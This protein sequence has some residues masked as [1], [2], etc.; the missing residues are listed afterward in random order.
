MTSQPKDLLLLVADADIEQ[1]MRGLLEN[2]RRLG[3][4]PVSYEIKRHLERDA[5]CARH[6]I[7]FLRLFCKQFRRALVIFDH[8]GSDR[9]SETREALESSLEQELARN[10]WKA[11]SVRV[12]ALEPEIE[13]WVWSPS[14]HVAKVLGWDDWDHLRSWLVDRQ[15]LDQRSNKPERPKEAMLAACSTRTTPSILRVAVWKA[16]SKCEPS[17]V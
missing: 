4:R 14:I 7:G 12:I 3:I 1:T 17:W 2:P 10:G 11:E 9:E 16:G 13:A 5:G 8:E 6:S 15:M